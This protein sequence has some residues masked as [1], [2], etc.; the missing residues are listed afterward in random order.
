MAPCGSR[1]HGALRKQRQGCQRIGPQATVVV[2][3]VEHAAAQFAVQT[4]LLQQLSRMR[5]VEYRQSVHHRAC[6]RPSSQPV[7]GSHC[8]EPPQLRPSPPPEHPI[9]RLEYTLAPPMPLHFLCTPSPEPPAA[10]ATEDPVRQHEG[11]GQGQ[12]QCRGDSCVRRGTR[13][14]SGPCKSLSTACLTS[15][16]VVRSY[17]NPALSGY[18]SDVQQQTG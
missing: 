13:L 6:G 18:N 9:F 10:V 2:E 11:Q 1:M 15:P 16:W 17:C 12:Q 3:W 5:S 4:G 8:V 14:G 7:R